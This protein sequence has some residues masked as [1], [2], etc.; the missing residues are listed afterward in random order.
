MKGCWNSLSTIGIAQNYQ[1]EQPIA[2]SH[3]IHAGDHGIDCNYCHHT[4]R[5]S[6]LRGF[7]LV[8]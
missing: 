2:F 7:D 6:I 3:K 1:P 5:S 8:V 4:A